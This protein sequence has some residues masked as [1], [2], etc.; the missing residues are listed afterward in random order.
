MTTAIA[1]TPDDAALRAELQR[2]EDE[3][4]ALA[5]RVTAIERRI[6]TIENTLK[7]RAEERERA[8]LAGLPD[9]DLAGA[10]GQLARQERER[11]R[12]AA[13][14]RVGEAMDVRAMTDDRL[15]AMANDPAG[16][17]AAEVDAVERELR[18]RR[19]NLARA[20]GRL[21]ARRGK[22]REVTDTSTTALIT[23]GRRW[24]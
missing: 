16:L 13:A 7:R 17:T 24:R 22:T 8:R 18:R 14:A 5:D 23:F 11:R 4:D 1:I 10:P 6:I 2:L 21:R 9:A 19:A 15:A 20:A 3:Q 12:T